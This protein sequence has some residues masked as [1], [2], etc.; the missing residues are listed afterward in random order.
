MSAF[1]TLACYILTLACMIGV[2]CILRGLILFV[3]L[4]RVRA[5]S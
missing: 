5:L 3:Y 2:F 1:F 4:Y